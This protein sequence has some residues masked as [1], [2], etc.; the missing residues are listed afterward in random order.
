MCTTRILKSIASLLLVSSHRRFHI[1]IPLH[2]ICIIKLIINTLFRFLIESRTKAG[3]TLLRSLVS[4]RIFIS[5]GRWQFSPDIRNSLLLSSKTVFKFSAH[6]ESTGPSNINHF[7]SA[8]FQKSSDN[9]ENFIPVGWNWKSHLSVAFWQHSVRP[10][11]RHRVKRAIQLAQ[12][13]WFWVDY[14]NLDFLRLLEWE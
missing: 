9:H 11:V 13:E 5:G 8:P 4:N 1:L 3:E 12:S 7:L 2:H 14:Q 6:I 10:F